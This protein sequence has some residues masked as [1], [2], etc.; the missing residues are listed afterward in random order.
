MHKP[1]FFSEQ[2]NIGEDGGSP[3]RG[4]RRRCGASL[5]RDACCSLP[6]LLVQG[7]LYLGHVYIWRG[8]LEL[9]QMP[10][11]PVGLAEQRWWALCTLALV[12]TNGPQL[13][14][15]IWEAGVQGWKSF[16]VRVLEKT[17]LG[18]RNFH[19]RML[20]WLLH[21]QPSCKQAELGAA[22]LGCQHDMLFEYVQFDVRCYFG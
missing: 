16:V 7:L 8:P 18:S 13:Q 21:P 1:G 9:R 22:V 4:H 5:G 2:L 20:S 11:H 10:P 3:L 14:A 6:I 17:R 19:L 12:C 15:C